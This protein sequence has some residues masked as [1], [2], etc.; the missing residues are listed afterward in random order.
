MMNQRASLEMTCW[1]L[2]IK[3]INWEME[4][5]LAFL[6]IQSNRIYKYCTMTV[7]PDFLEH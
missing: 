3:E 6:Y 1:I 7:E 4:I 5:D 2:K